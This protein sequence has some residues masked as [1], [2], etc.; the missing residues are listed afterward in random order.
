[1]PGLYSISQVFKVLSLHLKPETSKKGEMKRVRCSAIT[2]SP[3]RLESLDN[4]TLLK[5]R[6]SETNSLKDKGGSANL[7]ITGLTSSSLVSLITQWDCCIAASYCHRKV[8]E[9]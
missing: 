1:M 2:A 3:H 9:P 5:N 4:F 6:E 7:E 8:S